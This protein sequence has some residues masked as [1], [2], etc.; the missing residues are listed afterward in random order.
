MKQL[1]KRPYTIITMA[2]LFMMM[3]VY[4]ATNTPLV[5]TMIAHAVDQP[6]Y[7]NPTTTNGQIC[8]VAAFEGDESTFLLATDAATAANAKLSVFVQADWA[9]AHKDSLRKA[10]ADGHDILLLGRETDTPDRKVIG[11]DKLALEAAIGK[12]IAYYMPYCGEYTRTENNA[13]HE[14]GLKTVL[15]NKDTRVYIAQSAAQFSETMLARTH[16]GDFA[17][18]LLNRRFAETIP[19]VMAELQTRGISCVTVSDALAP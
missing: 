13:A 2:I 3:A 12:E 4:V 5:H 11:N 14:L 6:I 10:V 18:V 8:F 16:D 17:R 7:R 19:L 9:T 1:R 15:W